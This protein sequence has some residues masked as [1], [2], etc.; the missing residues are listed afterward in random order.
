MIPSDLEKLQNKI[1]IRGQSVRSAPNRLGERSIWI[2]LYGHLEISWF[3]YFSL[4]EN[5]RMLSHSYISAHAWT[6]RLYPWDISKKSERKLE[7][8]NCV[9]VS[10]LQPKL[11]V[12]IPSF[13]KGMVGYGNPRPRLLRKMKF[14]ILRILFNVFSKIE[15]DQIPFCLLILSW[16][17][18]VFLKFW[19][20]N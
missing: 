9:A 15:V 14:S 13:Y 2:N 11:S 7:L 12:L 19:E 8:K 20:E 17:P 4:S 16:S 5:I 1:W 3:I 6:H 10:S 18:I